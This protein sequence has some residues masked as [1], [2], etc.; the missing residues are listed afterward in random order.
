MLFSQGFG[1]PSGEHWLGNEAVHQI[2]SQ[3]QYSLRVE[4]KDWEENSAYALYDKFQLA[5]EK[6]QYRYHLNTVT[7][8][9]SFKRY[10]RLH[11]LIVILKVFLFLQTLNREL[12]WN[13]RTAK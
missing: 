2:T 9:M 6:Q 1:D 7:I 5:S 4:L 13:I 3:A 12:Q 8:N 11:V 10:F